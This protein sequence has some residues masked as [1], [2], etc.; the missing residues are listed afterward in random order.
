VSAAGAAL[1]DAGGVLRNGDEAFAA[2]VARPAA[3]LPGLA[4]ADLLTE[5][6]FA[7]VLAVTADLLARRAGV[8][9]LD[10]G[11]R[12]AD[13]ASRTLHLTCTPGPESYVLVVAED[14]TASR[15]SSDEVALLRGLLRDTAHGATPDLALSVALRRI[16]AAAGWDFAQLWLPDAAGTLR[17]SPA[18]FAAS[19]GAFQRI[20]QASVQTDLPVGAGLPGLAAAM[21]Q[22]A[23]LGADRATGR[24]DSRAALLTAAQ[25]ADAVSVPLLDQGETVAVIEL[26]SLTSRPARSRALALLSATQLAPRVAL[27]RAGGRIAPVVPEQPVQPPA[28]PPSA[29]GRDPLTGCVGALLLRDRLQMAQ[30]RAERHDSGVAVFAVDLDRLAGVN[31]AHGRPAGDQV[32]VEVARRLLDVLRSTDTCA[33]TADDEFVVVCE[34]F[35]AAAA[36]FPAADR[37]VSALGRPYVLADGTVVTIT[38][39]VGA[40]VG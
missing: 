29:S 14:V 20:R 12:A 22:A 24:T 34:E 10:V 38:A 9:A 33:R 15:A 8:A 13:G 11:L 32:L 3:A 31:A 6:D 23:G 37:I 5:A 30:A 2:V 39:C 35:D 25:V 7:A 36:A 19:D 21:G 26:L 40:A 17:C 4:L 16:C 28:P 1:M 18:W 27:Q